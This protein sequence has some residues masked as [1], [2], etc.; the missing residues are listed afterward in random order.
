MIDQFIEA[1]ETLYPECKWLARACD[2]KHDAE[3]FGADAKYMVHIYRDN[4]LGDMEESYLSAA[5]TL[6]GAFRG[7]LALAAKQAST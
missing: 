4:H 7:A 1:V 5:S 6:A 3:Q 2:G